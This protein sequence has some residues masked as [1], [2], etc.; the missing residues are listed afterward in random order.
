MDKELFDIG[1]EKEFRV[2]RVP[3]AFDA[4]NKELEQINADKTWEVENSTSV[5]VYG[6]PYVIYLFSRASVALPI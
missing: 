1:S 2:V 4:G 6:E 5:D 3:V